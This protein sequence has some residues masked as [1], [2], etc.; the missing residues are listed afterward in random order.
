AD[1]R[2]AHLVP[3][4][5]EPGATRR[6]ERSHRGGEPPARRRGLAVGAASAELS[7]GE[8]AAPSAATDPGT[9][10]AVDGRGALRHRAPDAP[11]GG[12]DRS[13]QRRR[14][15]EAATLSPRPRLGSLPRTSNTV[16]LARG[17]AGDAEVSGP[18]RGSGRR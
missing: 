9:Q 11:S 12:A 4:A 17:G 7:A 8:G 14:P 3:A 5:S 16:S 18:T 10:G 2:A 1:V 15:A 13:P 6:P